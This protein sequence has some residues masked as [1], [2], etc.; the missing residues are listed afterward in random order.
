MRDDIDQLMAL[1]DGEASAEDAS[2]AGNRRF[3]DPESREFLSKL[4]E[5]DKAFANAADELL[6]MPVPSR[7]VDAIR[8]P[9]PQPQPQTAEI[10]PFPRRRGIVGL[11]IAAGLAAVVATNTQ[12]F[13]SNEGPVVD[14]GTAGYAALLQQAMDSVPSDQVLNSDDGSVRIM[15]IVSFRTEAAAYCREFMALEGDIEF[16]GIACRDSIGS[17]R[18]LSERR[19]LTAPDGDEYRA[20]EGEKSVSDLP[21]GLVKAK[22]LSYAEEQAAIRTGWKD[23]GF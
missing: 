6:D 11:A 12:L 23:S 3:D 20:A 18:V 15:P 7:L 8:Q 22:E 13:K 14:S 1:H 16:S 21:S 9:E 10:I 2:A 19:T 5:A 4:T 17:W